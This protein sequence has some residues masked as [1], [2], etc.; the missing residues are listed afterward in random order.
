MDSLCVSTKSSLHLSHARLH[1]SV[2]SGLDISH[3][4][5]QSGHARIQSLLLLLLLLLLHLKLVRSCGVP[6]PPV[7]LSVAQYSA[8]FMTTSVIMRNARVKY[9][10]TSQSCRRGQP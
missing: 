1:V 2:Q 7:R 8:P 9:T 4:G 6:Q 3:A 5:I 10:L